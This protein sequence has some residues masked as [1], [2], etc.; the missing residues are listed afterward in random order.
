MS[1]G[2]G[3]LG[4]KIGLH[5]IPDHFRSL[6]ASRRGKSRLRSSSSTP[7]LAEKWSSI[8]QARTPLILLAQTVAP[9]PLPQT[10]MPRSNRLARNNGAAQGNDEI[11]IIIVRRQLVGAKNQGDLHARQPAA[12]LTRGLFQFKAATVIRCYS[13]SHKCPFARNSLPQMNT[14]KNPKFEIR[15]LRIVMRDE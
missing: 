3:E 7:C 8:K 14:N 1:R 4:L 10:A 9:T 2:A 6:D 5:Q 13:N 15:A 11:G 12:A